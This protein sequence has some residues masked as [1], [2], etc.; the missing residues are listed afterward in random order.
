MNGSFDPV[1]LRFA[2]IAAVVVGVV[3]AWW[4]FGNLAS[5]PV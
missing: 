2:V 5:G 4:L 1:W 3:L